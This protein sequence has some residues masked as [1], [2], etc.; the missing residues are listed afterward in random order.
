MCTSIS[1][2]T[3]I[4]GV[5]K[6]PRGWFPVNQ[7]TVAF[8]HATHSD[9]RARPAAGLR[10]LRPRHRGPGGPGDGPGFRQG[11]GRTAP[12]RHRRRR[13][14]RAGRIGRLTRT[15]G[16]EKSDHGP[17]IS[18]G[19]RPSGSRRTE[20]GRNPAHGRGAQPHHRAR[21]PTGRVRHLPRRHPGPGRPRATSGTS[22][23]SRSPTGQ[24]RLRRY[25]TGPSPLSTTPSSSASPS[26]TR[27]S[28][29]SSSAVSTTGPTPAGPGPGSS[30]TGTEDGAPTSSIPDG[31][32]LEILTRPYGS[33][34]YGAS[35][36]LGWRVV[37][38][39]LVLAILV[40]IGIFVAQKLR[41]ADRSDA[42]CAPDEGPRL[43]VR[44]RHRMA[45]TGRPPG[46]VTRRCRSSGAAELGPV[47]P[48]HR[49]GAPRPRPPPPPP[50]S[51]A[52]PMTPSPPRPGLRPSSP[53]RPPPR[54]GSGAAATPA[55]SAR[56]SAEP[57]AGA[58]CGR[59]GGPPSLAA[60]AI[61]RRA[62]SGLTAT[63]CPTASSMGT[64]VAESL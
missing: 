19:G 9:V 24:P 49:P 50:P 38:K 4:A 48:G 51:P 2:T 15:V 54:P 12:G 60:R 36:G 5:G 64:S 63:G 58:A 14:H 23:P 21:P 55:A 59:I 44:D 45:P 57:P 25:A 53:A 47:A 26:S 35:G 56:H 41:P 10:Q 31:H 46:R 34:G 30:T 13:G 6:G 42:D 43:G 33:G 28:G 17:G 18:V 39:L 29:A 22:G 20:Q 37:K 1:H 61:R 8:D 62:R 40:G 16:L 3:S 52:G 27:S 7:A 32:V 11:P